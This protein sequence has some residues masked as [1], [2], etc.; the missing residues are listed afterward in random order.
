MAKNASTSNTSPSLWDRVTTLAAPVTGWWNDQL[1]SDPE[2]GVADKIRAQIAG[3]NAPTGRRARLLGNTV[4]TQIKALRS[5]AKVARDFSDENLKRAQQWADLASKRDNEWRGLSARRTAYYNANPNART[6]FGLSPEQLNNLRDTASTRAQQLAAVASDKAQQLATSAQETTL[7]QQA[8]S[9]AATAADRAQQLAAAAADK[10]Q[11]LAATE[12]AQQLATN[13]QQLSQ[14][15]LD[16]L[17]NLRGQVLETDTYAQLRDRFPALAKLDNRPAKRNERNLTWLWVL[18]AGLGL[19][20]AGTT[21]YY[22]WRSRQI[23]EAESATMTIPASAEVVS[24]LYAPASAEG[25]DELNQEQATDEG[26]PAAAF[27]G[28]IHTRWYYP[29]ATSDQVLPPE[30][31]RVYFAS[32]TEA[33]GAGYTAASAGRGQVVTD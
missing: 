14:Q 23:E 30:S 26:M 2:P 17:N 31:A 33:R 13:A 11:Q 5:Q 6:F 10:A 12:Q 8:L 24:P 22:F 32:E 27:V 7:G 19:V 20:A 9:L 18:G 16:S 21:A 15:A 3:F 1:G 29:A 28:D 4:D 25:V